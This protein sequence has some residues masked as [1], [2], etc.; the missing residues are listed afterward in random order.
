[1][2]VKKTSGLC[3]MLLILAI[4]LPANSVIAAQEANA[5]TGN[6]DVE[7]K[8]TDVAQVFIVTSNEIGDS[9]IP[10]AITIIDKKNGSYPTI[11][12]NAAQIKLRGHST[13][14]L[15][16]HPYNIKLGSA[17]NVLGMPAGKKWCLL[18]NYLDTSLI[19]N[20]LA[21]DFAEKI[22]VPY[23]CKSR[24]ADVWVN[25][26]FEGNYLITVPVEAGVNRVDINSENNEYL[27]ELDS[28][29]VE[30]GVT[31]ISSGV[32]RFQLNEPESLTPEQEKWLKGFLV[33][34]EN[35]LRSK[36]YQNIRQYVDFDSFINYYIVQE[37]F[38]NLDANVSST[39]FYIKNNKIYAGPLWD[40]DLSAG[41]VSAYPDY[42]TYLVY[43]NCADY[44][45]G[46][47]NSNEGY[48]ALTS[49]KNLTG[50]SWIELLMQCSEFG[51]L[52]Y[53]RYIQLQDT[54]QNLYHN[55]SLGTNRIENLIK[56]YG[57]SFE[58]DVQ[59]WP[60]EKYRGS[61][62]YRTQ[63]KTY[64]ESIEFLRSFLINRNEWL[65]KHLAE[66]QQSGTGTVQQA[67]STVLVNGS[68]VPFEAYNINNN[69]YFKLRDIAQVV[70]GTN[71]QFEVTW[72]A[73]KG[74]VN[75]EANK[76]YTSVGGELLKGNGGAKTYRPGNAKVY[77]DGQE[78]KLTAYN[79]DGNNYVKLRDVAVLFNI[80]VAWDAN[81][82]AVKIDT[83]LSYQQN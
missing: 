31:Y 43:N 8:K 61:E 18:A 10:A 49:S 25:G 19:R 27:L 80:G 56:E 77:K 47:G 32:Y 51:S 76:P 65:L 7:S 14:N 15:E 11:T 34:M 68:A 23:S 69:N 36:Y 38:K 59:R 52:Y 20:K 24:F 16:K 3:I 41:N 28:N 33:N 17:Q 60:V 29:R 9:Y 26:V 64:K 45:N 6:M 58:R 73:Q 22:G 40:C 66:Y 67:S 4:I 82:N 55:N 53:Q 1:M 70:S 5:G 54:I 62:L 37:L 44:G 35:A 30:E 48:W 2:N 79:I 57:S 12:D 50:D 21:Y 42:K 81:S 39:R 75:L 71:K 78:I 74:A 13:Q 46:K 72:D 63:E 83:S